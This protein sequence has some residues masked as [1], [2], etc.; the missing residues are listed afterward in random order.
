[1]SAATAPGVSYR[2]ATDG[3]IGGQHAAF[4]AAEGELLNRHGF[5]WATPP[6]VDALAPGFRHFLQH[7]AGRCFV[8]ESEGRVVGYSA[9]WVRGETWFL[10]ALFIEPTFQGRGVGR[11]LIGLAMAGAPRQR[12]TI[13]DAIQPISNALYAKHGMLP[14]TPILGF[15]GT[16]TVDRPPDLVAAEPD[17]AV[18]ARLDVAVYG[19]DRAIDHAYWATRA[20]PTLWLRD[21]EPV[22]YSYRW[23][24][25]KIG[26]LGGFDEVGAAAA[27][28]AE[29]ARTPAATIMIPGTSRSLV[30]A[31]IDAGLQF[32]VPPGLLLLSEGVEPPSTLAISGYGTY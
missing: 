20:T 25:G 15:G 29:L 24:H 2:A 9:A 13:S 5:G 21:A 1:M 32:T 8:A 3:D 12:M 28:R 27:L 31:A 19:F 26:P 17:A 6:P 16:A 14:M 22:A 4:V 10:A 30:R 18:F 7:D 23:P 11:R